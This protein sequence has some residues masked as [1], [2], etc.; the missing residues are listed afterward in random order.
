MKQKISLHNNFVKKSATQ[1]QKAPPGCNCRKYP[2]P[3]NNQCLVDEVVYKATV[4]SDNSV[5][6]YTGLTAGTFKARHGGHKTSFNIRKYSNT[7]LSK[8]VWKLTDQNKNYDVDWEIIDRAPAFN[9]TTR[10]CRLCLKE[11]YYIMFYPSAAT[12]NDRS[13]F[14]STCRHRLKQLLMNT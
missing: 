7:T 12:L 6:T 3:L 1:A 5:E 9:P 2:C 13:E 8:H 11:K 4:T 10:S 14:F